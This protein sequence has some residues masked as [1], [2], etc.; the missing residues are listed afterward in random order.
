MLFF[1]MSGEKVGSPSDN[2][3]S[4][5]GHARSLANWNYPAH[6]VDLEIGEIVFQVKAYNQKLSRPKPIDNRPHPC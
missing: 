5:K 6:I 2:L 4:L 3:E 1:T